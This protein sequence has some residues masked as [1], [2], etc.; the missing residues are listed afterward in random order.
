MPL[1]TDEKLLS[2]SMRLSKRST[3]LMVVFIRGSDPLTRKA[4]C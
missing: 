3:K 1:T 2:L 4:S